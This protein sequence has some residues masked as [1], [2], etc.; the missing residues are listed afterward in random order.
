MGCFGTHHWQILA[1]S[2]HCGWGHCPW[3]T[4]PQ[5]HTLDPAMPACPNTRATA[6]PSLVGQTRAHASALMEPDLLWG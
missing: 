4:T 5:S 3:S 2:C 6:D 1:L